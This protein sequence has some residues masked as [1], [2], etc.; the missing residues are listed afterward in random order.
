MKIEHELDRAR[1]AGRIALGTPGGTSRVLEV[2]ERALLDDADDVVDRPTT[3]SAS[4]IGI[5]EARV[6]R[7]L[8][9]GNDLGDVAE[10]DE[11]EHVDR[12]GR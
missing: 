12:N 10:E 9:A 5:A 2:A 8:H 3:S 1:P 6:G 11:E 4:T 7:E